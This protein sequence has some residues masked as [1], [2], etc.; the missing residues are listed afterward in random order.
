MP[1]GF[2]APWFLGGL[3]LLGIPVLVHLTRRDRAAPVPFPSLMFVRK[4]PQATTRRRRLRDLPLLLLRALALLLLVAAF[5]RPLLDRAR[6][7]TDGGQGGRE[8]VVLLDRSYSMDAPGRWARAQDAARRAVETLGPDDRGSVVLFD[9]TAV[10]VAEHAAGGAAL[11]R[12]IDSAHV[13]AGATRYAPALAVASRILAR[14]PLARR[15]ALLVTDFQRAAWQDAPEARLPSGARLTWADVG[16]TMPVDVAVAAVELRRETARED[17]TGER[18]RPVARLV[19]RGNGTARTVPLTLAV[20]GR[21]VQT[22]SVVVTPSAPAT[23]TFDPIPVPPGWSHATVR[24]PADSLT[25]DDAFHFTFARGQ[26][27]RVLLVAGASRNGDAGLFLRRALAVGDAPPTVVTAIAPGAL[28]GGTL[29]TH[30]LVVLHDAPVRGAAGRQLADWVQ[31]GGGLLVAL[32]DASAAPAWEPAL[33]AQLPARIGDVVDR[34]AGGGARLAAFEQSHPVFAPFAGPHSGDLTAPRMLRFRTLTPAADARV[35]ARFEDGSPA[36]IERTV[37]RGR[38]LLWASTLD[39]W[40]T[41][42]A[43]DPV[44]VPLVHGMATHAAHFATTPPAYAVGQTIDPAAVAGSTGGAWVVEMPSG[45]RL[46]TG[47]PGEPSVA[48]LA[49]AGI[50]RVRPANSPPDAGTLL[51]ANVDA[52]EADPARLD[53]VVIARAVTDSTAARA[54]TTPA[55]ETRAEREA[56]QS[57]WRYLIFAAL[58]LLGVETFLSNRRRSLAFARRP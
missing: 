45:R 13:G 42:V 21:D 18:V 41:D 3:A 34:T 6:A 12:A 56:R 15:E 29:G 9:A 33:A 35:I 24:I 25:A 5:A 43:L 30:A 4:L 28:S 44:Y 50:Y 54:A 8:L 36:L 2:L 32:G 7:A 52:E 22:R 20:N 14:S 58:A 38:I 11:R 57:F 39:T 31:R 53:P 40:W 49:D 10:V 1:F 19:M 55:E 26:T 37:G 47:A 48:T 23:V 46:R 16:G 51:A 17:S 27:M